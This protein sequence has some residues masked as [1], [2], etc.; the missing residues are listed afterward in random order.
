M[1]RKARI[2]EARLNQPLEELVRKAT[3]ARTRSNLWQQEELDLAKAKGRALAA[4]FA[5]LAA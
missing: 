1:D 4:A 5:K 3:K 2:A